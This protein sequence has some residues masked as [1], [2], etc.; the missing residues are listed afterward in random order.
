MPEAARR[1]AVIFGGP[2]DG[3]DTRIGLTGALP[4]AMCSKSSAGVWLHHE[5]TEGGY[6]YVGSCEDV[7]HD[8]P[9]EVCNV[10]WPHG[11]SMVGH[12][13]VEIGPHDRHRCCCGTE[14]P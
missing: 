5:A 3:R 11:A 4:P 2:L 12:W 13:C 14:V 9:P 6:R 7:G 1:T 8:D 10:R